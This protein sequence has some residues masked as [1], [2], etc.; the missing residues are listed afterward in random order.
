[1]KQLIEA[2]DQRFLALEQRSRALIEK[3]PGDL[4]F[5]KPR[6]V[7]RS[8][9]GEYVLRSAGV[10]EKTFGGITTRLWDDPFEWTLPEAFAGP[11]DVL[12][13]LSETEDTR[14]AGFAYLKSDED[15]T[16]EIPSPEKLRS[17]FEIL[18]ETLA[19]AEHLQGRAFAVFQIL[20]DDKLPRFDK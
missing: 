15:L 1:M 7:P 17:L 16:R 2:F 5:Q 11:L 8:S 18:L 3:T 9:C 14:R 20:S 10:V 19:R 4:L 6:D 12:A 13:Y